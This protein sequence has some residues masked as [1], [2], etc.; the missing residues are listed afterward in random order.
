MRLTVDIDSDN[1]LMLFNSL[2][3]GLYFLKRFPDIIRKTERGFHVIYKGIKI[4][5]RE[6]FKYRKLL[7]DDENRQRLD[8]LSSLRNKQVLFTEKT[9]TCFGYIHP[10]WFTHIIKEKSPSEHFDICPN[11]KK[12][13]VKSRKVWTEKRKVLEIC[14]K[15]TK[16]IYPLR[17]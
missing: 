13:V 7:L 8:R 3:R 6:M 14:H 16:C 11:C 2:A 15:G 10:A 5:E 4:S 9:T 12:K 17:R 1:V